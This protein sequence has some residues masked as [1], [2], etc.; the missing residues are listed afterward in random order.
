MLS[1]TFLW[2]GTKYVV[3]KTW[4]WMAWQVFTRK[5]KQQKT[6][7]PTNPTKTHYVFQCKYWNLWTS[8]VDQ[9]CT[10]L[11]YKYSLLL[12][13]PPKKCSQF[14]YV[15]WTSRLWFPHSVGHPV[16]S[17]HHGSGTAV[18]NQCQAHRGWAPPV[19]KWRKLSLWPRPCSLWSWASSVGANQQ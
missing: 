19:L 4:K 5:K 9:V 10:A 11:W 7:K 2:H 17:A 6:K 18:Q 13:L 16:A 1:K 15:S 14:C 12:L 8:S 3:L